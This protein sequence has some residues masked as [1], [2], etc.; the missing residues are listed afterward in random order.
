M[1]EDKLIMT[2]ALHKKAQVRGNGMMA[3]EVHASFTQ[4]RNG[5]P[6]GRPFRVYGAFWLRL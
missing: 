1:Q 3:G 6:S 4:T 5:R 2:S